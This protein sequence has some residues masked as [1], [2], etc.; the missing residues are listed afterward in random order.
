[1]LDLIHFDLPWWNPYE[2]T[3]APLA[4]ELQSAAL[5]PPTLLTLLSNGQL[6]EHMLLELLA[7]ISTYLLLRRLRLGRWASL[8]GG[9]AFALNGTFAWLAHATV[10]PVAF[11]PLLLLGVEH[12]HAASVAG[13]HGGWWL[14]AI[15]GALSFYAG[16]PEVAYIDTALAV[17]WFAWRIGC[18]ERSRRGQL[19]AKASL[20]ALVGVLLAAPLIIAALDY[21]GH[22]NLG[23]H[24][25]GLLGSA[26]LPP[27]ALP[28]LLMPYVYGPIFDYRDPQ[29]VLTGIWGMVGGYL[30]IALVMFAALGLFSHRRRALRVVLAIWILLAFSRMY[31]ELP[32]LGSVLGLLPGMA[33]LAFFRYA[34][35]S[36][37]LAVIMLAALGIDDV[38]RAPQRRWRIAW[39]AIGSVALIAAAAIGAHSLGSQLGPRY[40]TRPFLDVAVGW[41]VL[42]VIAAAAAALTARSSRARGFALTMLV[43]VDAFAMYVVPELSAPRRVQL[44]H[45]PVAFLARHLG[46]SRLFTLG[47]L[48]PNYGSYYGLQ[49]LNVND[50]PI[51][52]RFADYVRTHLDSYVDPTVLVGNSGGGRSPFLPTPEQELLRNLP[53]YRASGVA[54]VLTPAGQPL[55]RSGALALVARTP[56]SWIYRLAG[57]APFF[58]AQG[59]RTWP[60][61]LRAITLTCPT[62]TTLVRRE[63]YMPGWS[64]TVG[65]AS[66]PIRE[67]DGLFEAVHVPAGTH[68]VS[69]DY[70]PPGI[71]A[72]KL[73]FVLGVLALSAAAVRRHLSRR[74]GESP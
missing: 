50:I 39:A 25:T 68:T 42:T 66:A 23:T 27:Q 13:R 64:A 3:G 1:M 17:L 59:C 18:L 57:G 48:Q 15:A 72:G 33:H 70:A 38:I 30:T 16:F 54:Y 56:S 44:D 5:F 34:T 60:S 11:L 2:G 32:V 51:P 62:A 55:P 49:S 63:T 7:G 69:F 9:I 4:G 47:P 45:Q 65:A 22:A 14:I 20:G 28:Q 52:S 12:A 43:A 46:V 24:T 71:L 61:G 35:P 29:Q 41:A 58:S 36:L 37:E 21:L 19:L 26:R 73:A 53:S 67:V 74:P 8:A 40:T 6:Y 10:N 31:G